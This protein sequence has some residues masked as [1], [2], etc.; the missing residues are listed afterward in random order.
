[1]TLEWHCHTWDL[2]PE[3]ALFERD[4]KTLFITDPHFGKAHAFQKAGIPIPEGAAGQDCDRLSQAIENSGARDLVILG[5]FLH[6]AE[7]RSPQI[8]DILLQWRSRHPEIRMRL[9]LGN[10]D[11][12]AGAPWKEMNFEI[13]ETSCSWGNLLCSHYPHKHP[14]LPVLA[15]HLHPGFRFRMTHGPSVQLPCFWITRNQIILP[16][17]GSFTGTKNIEPQQADQV[18]GV[19]DTEVFRIPVAHRRR[20]TALIKNL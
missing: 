4:T 3:R 12:S 13:H 10:H 7:G 16:A 18:W 17:F 1:M 20:P 9:I 19:A 15:G 14:S 11:F 6:A 5:D 8:R 2:L